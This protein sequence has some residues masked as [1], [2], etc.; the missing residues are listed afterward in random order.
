MENLT[1]KFTADHPGADRCFPGSG[2][3]LRGQLQ[4]PVGVRSGRKITPAV[5]RFEDL[6]QRLIS[7]G[8]GF[9]CWPF[10]IKFVQYDSPTLIWRFLSRVFPCK[11]DHHPE[12]ITGVKPGTLEQFRPLRI[13]GAAVGH[14]ADGRAPSLSSETAGQVRNP[15]VFTRPGCPRGTGRAS[16]PASVS[17][18]WGRRPRWPRLCAPR[19][20]AL[21]R[22]AGRA[23]AARP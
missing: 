14:H 23:A 16:G 2:H 3:R 21:P 22:G 9:S 11:V 12:T 1:P 10:K 13:Y 5:S 20:P 19:R 6:G 18:R 15:S 8:C 4:S 7:L 17:G